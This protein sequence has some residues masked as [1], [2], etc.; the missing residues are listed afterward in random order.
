MPPN[1]SQN[2][3]PAPSGSSSVVVQQY[4]HWLYA[5]YFASIP[6]QRTTFLWSGPFYILLFLGILSLLLFVYTWSMS[7][8]H[9]R[10]GE[11]YG[12]VSFGGLILERIGIVEAFT[13]VSTIVFILWAAY[14]WITQALWGQVY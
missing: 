4:Y 11:L 2:M 14:F 7:R 9:R 3:P 6:A 10:H 5:N 12:V 1:W 8:A 13:Y